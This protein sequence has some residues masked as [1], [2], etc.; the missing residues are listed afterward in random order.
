VRSTAV[1]RSATTLFPKAPGASDGQVACAGRWEL[2]DRSGWSRQARNEA[3]ALCAGCALVSPCRAQ[4]LRT[5]AGNV[6][7]GGTTAAQ[8]RAARRRA[9]AAWPPAT[10]P[11][12]YSFRQRVADARDGAERRHLLVDACGQRVATGLTAEEAMRAVALDAD[13]PMV[14]VLRARDTV[15]TARRRAERGAPS[16]ARN[17]EA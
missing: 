2:F 11:G 12:A 17:R 14:E 3:L 6:V 16:R 10:D 5:D 9:D 7:V 13:I 8:R 1:P 4:A 15:A